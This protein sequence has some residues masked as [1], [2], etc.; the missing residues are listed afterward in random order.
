MSAPCIDACEVVGGPSSPAPRAPGISLRAGE[1]G[2]FASG[3][4]LVPARVGSADADATRCGCCEL[5]A[6]SASPEEVEPGEDELDDD[7]ELA[8]DRILDE[9]EREDFA[10]DNVPDPDDLGPWDWMTD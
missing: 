9:Q 4:R 6:D 5:T 2:P 10:R 7:G 1:A 8:R 3:E